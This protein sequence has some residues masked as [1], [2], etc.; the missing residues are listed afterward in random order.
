MHLLFEILLGF[1]IYDWSLEG[2][3]PLSILGMPEVKGRNS[4]GM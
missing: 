4:N 1:E 2:A 3:E